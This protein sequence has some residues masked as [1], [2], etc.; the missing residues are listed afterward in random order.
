MKMKCN[1]HLYNISYNSLFGRQ[2]L[3]HLLGIGGEVE[4]IEHI[5]STY[6]NIGCVVYRINIRAL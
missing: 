3:S 2:I 5:A 6:F 4:A 1:V